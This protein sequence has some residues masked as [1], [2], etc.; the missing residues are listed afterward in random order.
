[1]STP[2]VCDVLVSH[3][4]DDTWVRSRNFS[5][6]GGKVPGFIPSPGEKLKF[7]RDSLITKLFTLAHGQ[8]FPKSCI[9]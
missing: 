3:N 9:I 8:Q 7:A 1:M 6:G 4:Q 2:M 5:A